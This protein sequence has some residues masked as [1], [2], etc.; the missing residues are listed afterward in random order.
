MNA[1]QRELE[2][3]FVSQKPCRMEQQCFI[4]QLTSA[5]LRPQD[6][7][8]DSISIRVHWHLF[9]VSF[10]AWYSCK[11]ARPAFSARVMPI[12]ARD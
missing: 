9:A 5:N 8:R 4:E 2:K 11:V 6:Q 3:E 12:Y 7:H 1:N 10:L